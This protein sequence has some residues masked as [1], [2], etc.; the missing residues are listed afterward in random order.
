MF[1]L[2][3]PHTAIVKTVAGHK[4]AVLAEGSQAVAVFFGVVSIAAA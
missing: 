1:D 4:G 2:D 3:H